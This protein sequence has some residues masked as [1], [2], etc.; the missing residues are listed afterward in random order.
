MFF[1]HF[2]ISLLGVPTIALGVVH[3]LGIVSGSVAKIISTVV[4]SYSAI[5]SAR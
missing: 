5:R 4:S 1:P 3:A 2:I